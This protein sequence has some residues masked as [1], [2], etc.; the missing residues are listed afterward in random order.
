MLLHS[1]WYTSV[2]TMNEQSLLT[3]SDWQ[4][5][6][7][8]GAQPRALLEA[9]AQ[10][11]ATQAAAPDWI[12][13]VS[14][15]QL[16]GRSRPSKHAWPLPAAP[17][18]AEQGHLSLPACPLRSGQHRRR[19]MPTTAA[20]PRL[21]LRPGATLAVQRLLSASAVCLEQDQSTSSPPASSA[22]AR[23][24]GGLLL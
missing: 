17:L 9:R 1:D 15:A 4:R 5:A 20:C 3:L 7:L 11:L 19:G 21:R 23:P 2:C 13:R 18:A 8:A 22:R 12:H 10:R 6:Y 24:M 14:G 16:N